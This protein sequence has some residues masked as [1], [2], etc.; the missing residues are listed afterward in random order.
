[1]RNNCNLYLNAYGE[2]VLR[3][4][5]HSLFSMH[6]MLPG[7]N[8]QLSFNLSANIDFHFMQMLYL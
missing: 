2:H 6:E 3:M 7:E 5:I 4:Y 8:V 1:M